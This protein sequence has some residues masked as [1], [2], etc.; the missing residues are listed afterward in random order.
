MNQLERF[1]EVSTFIFDVD[2]VLTNNLVL[3][4]EAGELLRQMNVKDGYAIKRAIDTGYLV[5]IITGGR[6]AGVTLRLQALGV[7]EVH[8]G[9]GHKLEVYEDIVRRLDLDEGAILYMGDDVPDYEVMRRV[10]FATCPA[11]ACPEII[12][13]SQYVSPLPG[14]QGCVRDVIEK[15]MKIQGKWLSQLEEEEDNSMDDLP[16]TDDG[17]ADDSTPFH[18]VGA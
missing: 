4:T 13:L 6:S 10:G 16:D 12:Q 7:H 9:V 2:G 18:A 17:D 11:D 15:V 1:S 8:A 3:V 5:A 14:G